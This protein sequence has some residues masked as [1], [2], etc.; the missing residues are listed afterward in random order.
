MFNICIQNLAKYNEGELVFEWL[1]LPATEEEIEEVLE[2]VLGKDEEYM[3]VDYEN[4]IG[5]EVHE[6]SN[7]YKLN[8]LAERLE[9]IDD[10]G[11][12]TIL[13]AALEIESDL[14]Y[15][16]E[17]VEQDG[18]YYYDAKDEQ[19]LGYYVVNEDFL[20]EI[21]EELM[22]YINY[23]AVGRD[24]AINSAGVFVDGYYV[25]IY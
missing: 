22:G 13:K 14:E 20:G 19:D 15:A 7:I 5:Y 1:E 6:Y 25:V 3:I 21:S 18:F 10:S 12:T 11:L 16:I 2:R 9:R 17:I 4:S 24:W 23:E 8:E